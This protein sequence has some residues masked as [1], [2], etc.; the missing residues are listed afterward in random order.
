MGCREG[1]PL[2]PKVDTNIVLKTIVASP[3]VI[4]CIVSR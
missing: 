2:I 1:K 4:M 3:R